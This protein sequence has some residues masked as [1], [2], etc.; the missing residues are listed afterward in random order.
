M[1]GKHESHSIIDD[2]TL[3]SCQMEYI[4]SALSAECSDPMRL[5]KHKEQGLLYLSM[6]P[7]IN[8]VFTEHVPRSDFSYCGLAC[9]SRCLTQPRKSSSSWETA[10]HHPDGYRREVLYEVFI[11]LPK[12]C[13]SEPSCT[14]QALSWPHDVWIH[15]ARSSYLG[16]ERKIAKCQEIYELFGEEEQK[17][18]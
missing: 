1:K 4:N 2:H 18:N 17:L 12:T 11:K 14:G 3:E 13:N 6:E 10:S 5:R 15:V 7:V 8:K 16:Q 9:D